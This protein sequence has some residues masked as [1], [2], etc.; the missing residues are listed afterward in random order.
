MTTHDSDRGV[1]LRAADAELTLRPDQGGRISSLRIGGTEL[2]RQ[3]ER[4]GSFIMAPWCGR[5]REGRFRNGATAH[6][7]PLNAGPRTVGS[8]DAPNLSGRLAADDDL[9]TWWQPAADDKAPTLTSNLTTPGA[10]V[11]AVRV[12]PV[13]PGSET[14]LVFLVG[15]VPL[16]TQMRSVPPGTAV[17]LVRDVEPRDVYDRLLAYVHRASD[18]LVVNVSLVAD[19][20]AAERHLP[21]NTALRP[22]I[23]RAEQAAR[24]A[25]LGLWGACGG[26]HVAG[27]ATAPASMSCAI[28][29][30]P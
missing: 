6:E 22:D 12:R 14:R 20:F 5:T 21:P 24:S 16:A 18:G 3:G 25:G 23:E 10:V 30:S 11:R 13:L 1:R 7:L 27:P 15:T 26:P 8:S 17:R 29:S 9:R 28:S 4:F 19:G 2:L